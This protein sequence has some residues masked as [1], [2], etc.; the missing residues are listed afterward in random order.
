MIERSFRERGFGVDAMPEYRSFN[1]GGGVLGAGFRVV[2]KWMWVILL[3]AV[4]LTGAAVS[5]SLAQPPM[6]EASIKILIEEQGSAETPDDAAD[7]Q[8]KTQKIAE[9]FVSPPILEYVVQ[10]LN[11]QITPVGFSRENLSVEQ[12]PDTQLL[13]VDYKDRSPQRAQRVADIL[14]DVFSEDVVSMLPEQDPELSPSP[15]AITATVWERAEAPEEPVSPKPVRNGLLGLVLGLTLGVGLAF[16]WEGLNR[17]GKAIVFPNFLVAALVAVA[18]V[19]GFIRPFMVTAHYIP[20]ES[21]LPTLEIDD[22]VLVNKYI[23]RFSE[24][25]RGDVVVFEGIGGD[26][27]TL[28]K[29]VVGVEGDQVEVRKGVLFVNGERWVEPYL[30]EELP[31]ES[32]YG[33]MQVPPNHVFV[34]GDNRAESADSR[35]FGPVPLENIEGEAFL[36]FWPISKVGLV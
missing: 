32:F 18:L 10:Q 1:K 15:N 25:E 9:D 20:S 2:S 31:D 13:Q 14:G 27:Q 35:F 21:M 6:Y 3:V 17:R 30:N 23:Y 26:D 19:F 16:L 34:M 8:R 24:P 11:S 33:P 22:R 29:R 7:L 36:R 12:I 4:A 28:I 5:F